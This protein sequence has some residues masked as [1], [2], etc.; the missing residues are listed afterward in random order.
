MRA[1]GVRAVCFSWL[2]LLF[3]ADSAV[4][5]FLFL[6][7]FM[8]FRSKLGRGKSRKVFR[9]GAERVHRKNALLGSP[10]RGGIRL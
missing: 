3:V 5:F 7:G 1:L 4:S 2:V 9:R 10:M 8:A 6:G